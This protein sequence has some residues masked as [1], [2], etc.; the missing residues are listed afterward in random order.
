MKEPNKPHHNGDFCPEA[1]YSITKLTPQQ[2]HDKIVARCQHFYD[3]LCTLYTD[4]EGN[5][6]KSALLELLIDSQEE[7]FQDFLYIEE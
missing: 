4:S 7:L 2:A 1:E 3:L 5:E 6:E